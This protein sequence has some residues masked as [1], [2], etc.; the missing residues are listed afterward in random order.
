MS[1]RLGC[2]A[3]LGHGPVGSCFVF[4]TQRRVLKKITEIK[5]MRKEPSWRTLTLE[6]VRQALSVICFLRRG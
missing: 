2:S 6:R 5:G 4:A 3:L 1:E